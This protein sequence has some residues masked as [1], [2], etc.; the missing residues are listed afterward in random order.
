MNES[1]SSEFHVGFTRVRSPAFISR[2]SMT[3]IVVFKDGVLNIKP[4]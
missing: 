1:P 3:V 2:D 4:E